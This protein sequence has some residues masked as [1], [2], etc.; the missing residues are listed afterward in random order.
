MDSPAGANQALARGMG[1]QVGLPASP[2]D[3]TVP[4]KPG[5]A[6]IQ[7]ETK[8][9]PVAA[10]PS[11]TGVGPLSDPTSRVGSQP[12]RAA[13]AQ[14]LSVPLSASA[15]T[16]VGAA[17]I[18][19]RDAPLAHGG[20][21][22]SGS[23]LSLPTFFAP[24]SAR[25]SGEEIRPGRPNGSPVTPSV[26]LPGVTYSGSTPAMGGPALSFLGSLPRS[27]HAQTSDGGPTVP[28][29]RLSG[30]HASATS[31]AAPVATYRQRPSSADRGSD[32]R[33]R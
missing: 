14:D 10:R 31:L 9:V 16:S 28:D 15:P 27:E 23:V 26:S 17:Q 5:V 20:L 24:E 18:A 4:A 11:Q 33:R 29:A 30:Q 13:A 1:E 25:R 3:A 8:A 7:S 32:R 12:E 19:S 21:S 2:D 6:E 22:R